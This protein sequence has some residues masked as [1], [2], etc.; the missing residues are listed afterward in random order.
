MIDREKEFKNAFYFLKRWAKSPLTPSYT[1]SYS[2]GNADR[3]PA[4]K[5]Y[6]YILSLQKSSTSF[7]EKVNLLNTFLEKADKEYGKRPFMG[8][9]FYYNMR[10]YIRR[11]I[12]DIEN[13]KHVQTRRK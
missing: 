6:D 4:K 9:A 7:E 5:V 1:R 10:S 12:K 3:E 13:G 2:A 8:S 11:S